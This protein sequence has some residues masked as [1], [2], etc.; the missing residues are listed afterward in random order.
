MIDQAISH[1]RIVEKL[2]EGG[3]GVVYKAEDTKLRRL[4][5]LKFLTERAAQ[6]EESRNRFIQEARAAAALNHP[7]ICTVYEID[8]DLG[9]LAMEYVDGETV[10]ARRKR[11]ALPIEEGLDIAIQTTEGLRAAHEKGIVHRDIKSANLMVTDK[12][13][14][15]IM[16][17]GLARLA[18]R[19][20]LT[21]SG[22]SPGT[23]AY[24]APEVYQGEPA[25]ERSDIWS[26]GVVLYEL[27]AGRMPFEGEYEAAMLYGVLHEEPQPLAELCTD[28]P[29]ELDRLVSKALAKDPGLRY[30]RVDE[31]AA[32]LKA[33]RAV[34]ASPADLPRAQA[35]QA[36]TPSA[37]P[38]SAKQPKGWK[39]VAIAAALLATATVGLWTWRELDRNAREKAVLHQITAT[40]AENRVTAAAVSP[41]GSRLA[42]AELGGSLIVQ[43]LNSGGRQLL[44]AP[45][46]T[47]IDTI[48]WIGSTGRILI[49]GETDAEAR[50]LW[51]EDL[52][53]SQLYTLRQDA[54]R[55]IASPD[56]Q[57]IAFTS[58][59]ETEIWIMKADGGDARKLVIGGST[60]TFPFIA[61]SS[62]SRR[63]SY[64]RRHYTTDSVDRHTRGD[65]EN[66]FRRT[67]ET[68]DL[69]GGIVDTAAIGMTSG[70]MLADGRILF[71]QAE[72]RNGH[73][74]NVWE[75]RTDHKTGQF[76]GTPRRLTQW[77]ERS[78]A[79][80]S[81]S[82]DGN[83]VGFL[84]QGSQSDIYVAELT[85]GSLQAVRRLTQED[86][87]EYPHAW[88]PDNRAVI[89]EKPG[90]TGWDLYIQGIDERLAYPLATENGSKI[91]PQL[92]P[93]GGWVLYSSFRD[94]S[95]AA[96][97]DQKLMRVPIGGGPQQLVPTGP[98]D[99]FRCALTPG[100]RCILRTIQ[101][102]QYVYWDL[103]PVRGRGKELARTAWTPSILGD[104]ALSADGAEAA[105]PNHDPRQARVLLIDLDAPPGHAQATS[106][107]QVPGLGGLLGLVADAKGDGWFASAT[108][109]RG[110]KLLHI[111]R[112]GRFQL[113]RE[114]PS[115]TWGV[116]SPNGQRLAFVDQTAF[117]NFWSIKLF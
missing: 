97:A 90:K 88:T 23:P 21:R 85:S 75:L 27:I 37:Q 58:G 94:G 32:D 7:N 49:S 77:P 71:L 67:F 104:W 98:F 105:M 117:S 100:K 2:G 115:S 50:T 40:L 95:A 30:Q 107:L 33:L 1:Y 72:E 51:A 111:D 66:N 25:D 54:R 64:Q 74:F 110:V 101:N 38:S 43:D 91:M 114:C 113:L 60:D 36:K 41:D 42:Y 103:D 109:S 20:R 76:R 39:L 65:G 73:N 26:L 87:V 13:R 22:S 35:T 8:E 61:F 59:D 116:P 3:M 89:F 48:S 24:M 80:I 68:V 112:N 84:I 56:G 106:E 18:G 12:G 86:M 10:E 47:L 52:S 46:R 31:V 55:G 81:C 108:S 11:R 99:E 17:F 9:F 4:V 44:R 96:R 82:A 93:D 29:L 34:L 62:D 70:C 79:G 28:V 102:R 45:E 19:A 69:S 14:V 5:A 57:V 78:L 63:V 16:D 83:F 6:D 53:D 15:K 92:S